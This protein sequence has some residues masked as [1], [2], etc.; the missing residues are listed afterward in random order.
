MKRCHAV[1]IWTAWHFLVLISMYWIACP[2]EKV[3]S[4]VYSL[5]VST[6]WF[7]RAFCDISDIKCDDRKCR[8]YGMKSFKGQDWVVLG[9]EAVLVL[10]LIFGYK[11]VAAEN[12]DAWSEE[13]DSNVNEWTKKMKGGKEGEQEEELQEKKIAITF[14]DGPHP[15]YTEKLLDGLKERDVKATFFVLGQ[16]AEKYPEIIERMK[17]EG[18]IIGNHT[19]THI[20]LRSGN[21]SQFRDELV[22]TNE[23][24]SGITGEEVQYV[25]PPYGTWD[26]KLEEELNMFPVLWNVDPNDWCTGNADKV[27][28]AI[29][30]K[31]RENSVILL[32]DCY[33]S[34]VDAALASIDILTERGFEFVTVE[35]IL[36]E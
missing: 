1:K 16:N 6:V 22:L 28:K 2:V 17:E 30:N 29:V 25:R 24:I 36:F 20:Q 14:D 35:E 26:K 4:G 23:T 3:Q 7:V 5:I 32:H 31:A 13:V 27:T 8:E 11:N 18:H 12:I 15:V 19:Y 34:S 10:L 33:Q 21:R 9:L